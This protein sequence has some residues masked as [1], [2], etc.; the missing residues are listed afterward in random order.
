MILANAR[1][2]FADRLA[3]GGL[4]VTDGKIA[5]ISDREIPPE[6]GEPVVDLRGQ[7]LAPGFIDMHI[8]GALRRDSMEATADAFST[9][10][11]HHVR[12][13]TT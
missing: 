4:R 2:I 9:I 13:G 7:F 11:R 8:H 12:H 1:L 6:P 10:C 3:H 5:G